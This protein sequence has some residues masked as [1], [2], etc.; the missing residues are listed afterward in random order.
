[1]RLNENEAQTLLEEYTGPFYE[2]ERHMAVINLS[3]SLQL[4]LS[5]IP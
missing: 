4:I 3:A 1:M 2:I 5:K